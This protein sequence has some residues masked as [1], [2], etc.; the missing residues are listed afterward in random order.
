MRRS[1][2][3]LHG[4]FVMELKEKMSA[5]NLWLC[6]VIGHD[7]SP[8]LDTV[9]P[10]RL[11]SALP[12]LWHS[13]HLQ[14]FADGVQPQLPSAPSFPC[15]KNVPVPEQRKY[16]GVGRVGE[17]RRPAITCCYHRGC[18]FCHVLFHICI[19]VCLLFHRCCTHAVISSFY[20]CLQLNS[21]LILTWQ[22]LKRLHII[23]R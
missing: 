7:S 16:H 10:W 6:M 5:F 20:G 15:A 3:C 9:V 2:C 1:T 22:K 17:L 21:L 19:A 18:A 14:Q 13:A 11:R 12:L 8:L 23:N 4:E